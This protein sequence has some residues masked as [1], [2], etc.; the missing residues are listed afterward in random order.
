[1]SG[2]VLLLDL[3]EG[4]AENIL[5]VFN[6]IAP[7]RFAKTLAVV[8]IL[9]PQETTAALSIECACSS[10]LHPSSLS[11]KATG[12]ITEVIGL[13]KRKSLA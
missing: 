2:T 10:H 7:R 11:S 4:L 9:H 8:E 5:R 1:V 6:A 3:G 13:E 12:Q